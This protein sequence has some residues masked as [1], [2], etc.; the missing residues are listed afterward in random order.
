MIAEIGHFCLILALCVAFVQG[1]LPMVGARN[2]NVAFMRVGRYAAFAQVLLITISFFSL[3]FCFGM[4]DFS[5]A[6]VAQNSNRSL[7]LIYRLCAVWG[8]HE[9]SML[10]WVFI[11]SLWMAAVSLFSKRLPLEMLART[12]AVLSWIAIGFYLFL[13]ITSNPFARLLPNFPV[14]GQ[15]L[16]PILQDPG[17]VIHPPMLYMGYVGF[18]VVFAFSIAALISKRLD[19]VW[20]RWT[21]PWT[22][23]AWCFLTYGIVL[24]SWWAYRELG[25]G[26]W[27]FWDPVENASFLPWLVGT[28][29]LHSLSATE[30]RGV[31]KAWTVLLAVSAFS[32]SLLGT[33]LV[34]SGI[35]I[36]VHAFAVDPKRG[37]FMLMFLFVVIGASLLLYALRSRRLISHSG[38]S[39]YS[40]EM[41]ILLN[42]T[43]LVVAMLTVLLG[44]IYPLIIQA[45][46]G[47]KVS[48][49]APYFNLIFIPLMVPFLFLMGIG[50]YFKWQHTS[51]FAVMYRMMIGVV[52]A[53]ALAIGLP[54]MFGFSFKPWA[55][56]GLGLA[57]WIL[58]QTLN[59][60]VHF[61]RT[62]LIFVKRLTRS[63]WA[64]V[65]A[66]CGIAVTL[67]GITMVTQFEQQL[68]LSM[69]PNSHV[70][71]AGYDFEFKNVLSLKGPNYSGA[72][73]TF[74]VRS[75]GRV[76]TVM[77]PEQRVFNVEQIAVAKTAINT[78]P[79]RDLYIALG[80]P[81]NGDAWAVRIYYK[82]FI[83]WIWV[84]GLLMVLGGLM[85]VFDRRYRVK[86]RKTNEVLDGEC[87]KAI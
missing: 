42:N 18:S 53:L 73:A 87:I 6:Y 80:S 83:R 37:Q 58:T 50:P 3:M 36:S 49:G 84:G 23:I 68:N 24:G 20:A 64:M 81:L 46:S 34:R 56:L 79:W 4:N 71:L 86:V 5:V 51:M 62:K 8:A 67:I 55:I 25:W 85:A 57:F 9:G 19:A 59:Q 60:W 30:K 1:V 72:Q 45:L 29:L 63:Q 77:H 47:N 27:W 39:L 40:R 43:F 41:M 16:N 35:L 76:Y 22:T 44:T 70:Q 15:D 12:L 33:F 48:V 13:L 38:F 82:P 7:P 11:L 78:K 17:M 10:L 65:L 31:F 14:N 66:H 69:R 61:S 21:R 75:E 54:I 32:L 52:I 28:A 2:G 74:I 26:G